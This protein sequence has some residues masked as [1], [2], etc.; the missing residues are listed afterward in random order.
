[1]KS[2]KPRRKGQSA[3]GFQQMPGRIYYAAGKRTDHQRMKT[4]VREEDVDSGKVEDA[5]EL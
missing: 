3:A 5:L 1:M 4:R 2:E